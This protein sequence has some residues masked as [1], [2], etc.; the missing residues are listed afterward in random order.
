MELDDVPVS[1]DAAQAREELYLW[2]PGPGDVPPLRPQHLVVPGSEEILTNLK[3][4]NTP[5][6]RTLVS[7]DTGV[8]PGLDSGRM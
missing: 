5:A 4:R 3:P 8:S 7:K 6:V 2:E 1:G